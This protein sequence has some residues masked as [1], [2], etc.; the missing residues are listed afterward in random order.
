ML[1]CHLGIV[2]LLTPGDGDISS[3]YALFHVRV[4]VIPQAQPDGRRAKSYTP[5]KQGDGLRA[6]AVDVSA[7]VP[8]SK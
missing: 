2:Q 6:F 1:H 7:T 8:S 4:S 3:M 5:S